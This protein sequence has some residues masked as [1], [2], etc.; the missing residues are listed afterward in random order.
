MSHDEAFEQHRTYLFGVAYR[1]LGS[2]AEAE[3]LVQDSY[4]RWRESKNVENPRAYLS[5]I[6][7]RLCLDRLKQARTKREIYVGP[8][9]PEPIINRPDLV[10]EEPEILAQ[11]ISYALMLALE[12]LSPLER[13]AFLLHD[14]FDNGYDEIAE[15]LD[16]SEASC[17]QLATRARNHIR[18]ERPRFTVEPKRS[19][20]IA[21]AFFDAMRSGDT[22]ALSAVLAKDAVLHTDGGGKVSSALN[23]VYSAEKIVRFYAGLTRKSGDQRSTLL[24]RT[25]IN[26]MPGEIVRANDGILQT[27]V[28][29]ITD[30]KITAI[31]IT[32]NPDKLRHLSYLNTAH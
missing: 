29:E 3:D 6:V 27:N 1:M 14:V 5:K 11:D 7:S 18:H 10:T 31:Y 24:R 12:R 4:L 16:R 21:N 22:D 8:W 28:V 15:V 9:L 2:V 30:G 19:H 17:R 26:G 32:R 23:I 13:A 20:E 25:R